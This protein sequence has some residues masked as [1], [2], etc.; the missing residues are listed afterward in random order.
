VEADRIHD[1]SLAKFFL[2]RMAEHDAI[3]AMWNA[4]HRD[5]AVATSMRK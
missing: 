5:C 1:V 3:V 4:R 2:T